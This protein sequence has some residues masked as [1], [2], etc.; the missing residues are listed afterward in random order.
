MSSRWPRRRRGP[1]RTGERGDPQGIA[2]ASGVRVFA[3]LGGL[4]IA[5][6]G[7]ID[8]LDVKDQ[9]TSFAEIEVGYRL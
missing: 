6:I 4:G 1:L 5:A 3:L 8:V 2:D 7:V 9:S